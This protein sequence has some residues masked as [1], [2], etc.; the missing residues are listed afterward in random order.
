MSQSITDEHTTIIVMPPESAKRSIMTEIVSAFDEEDLIEDRHVI[1][2]AR[3]LDLITKGAVT[4]LLTDLAGAANVTVLGL[5]APFHHYTVQRAI[6]ADHTLCARIPD[7]KLV[8]IIDRDEVYQAIRD[9]LGGCS[10][11]RDSS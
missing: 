9:A 7:G 3:L 5:S 11:A 8:L 6:A 2:D 10:L 4:T 1:V